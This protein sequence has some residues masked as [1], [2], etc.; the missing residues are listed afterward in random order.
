MSQEAVHQW[1]QLALSLFI[2]F[3]FHQQCIS[4]VL[5]AAA[6]QEL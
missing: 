2:H 5:G 3:S 1:K 4:E 6:A